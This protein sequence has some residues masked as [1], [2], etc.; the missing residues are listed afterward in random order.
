MFSSAEYWAAGEQVWRAEHVGENSPVHLKTS[1]ALP[2]GF[3]AMSAKFKDAQAAEGGD[4]AGVDH[5]FEIPLVAA[6]EII[7]FKH[8][9]E[10]PGFEDEAFEILRK[11]RPSGDSKSWWRFWK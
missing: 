1:G 2:T 6:R 9:E 11:G 7:G 10:I 8:D 4:E 5:Y 3:E